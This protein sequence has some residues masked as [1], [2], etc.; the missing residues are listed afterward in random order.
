MRADF[1]QLLERDGEIKGLEAIWKTRDGS[2]IHV[3]ENAKLMRDEK[4]EVFFE[5]TVEDI[6]QSKLAEEAQRIR[7]QQFEI[8]NRIISRATWPSPC[9]KCWRSSWT[10]WSSRWLSTRPASS[11]TTT[12]PGK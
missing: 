2:M 10:A 9:R 11:C 3:R 5:G 12:R 7:T 1:I 6:T 4:G 8:L